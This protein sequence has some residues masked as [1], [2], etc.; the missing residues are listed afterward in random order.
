MVVAADTVQQVGQRRLG[1]VSSLTWQPDPAASRPHGVRAPFGSV[2]SFD[3]RDTP[4][5]ARTLRAHGGM[6]SGARAKPAVQSAGSQPTIPRYMAEYDAINTGGAKGGLDDPFGWS[7]GSAGDTQREGLSRVSVDW[8]AMR[9]GNPGAAP[10]PVAPADASGDAVHGS[11][12]TGLPGAMPRGVARA[13]DRASTAARSVGTAGGESAAARE[14]QFVRPAAPPATGGNPASQMPVGSKGAVKARGLAPGGSFA[15]TPP[16]IDRSDSVV[17]PRGGHLGS[18]VNPAEEQ[19]ARNSRPAGGGGGGGGS[20]RGKGGGAGGSGGASERFQLQGAQEQQAR[21]V[22]ENKA[23]RRFNESEK[24]GLWAK[25]FSRN[26]R[27]D[28]PADVESRLQVALDTSN[29]LTDEAHRLAQEQRSLD[30]RKASLAQNEAAKLRSYQSQNPTDGMARYIEDRMRSDERIVGT[31]RRAGEAQASAG[32]RNDRDLAKLKTRLSADE[33]AQ[34]ARDVSLSERAQLDTRKEQLDGLDAEQR[35]LEGYSDPSP[36]ER[37]RLD[38]LRSDEARRNAEQANIDKRQGKLDGRV[39]KIESDVAARQAKANEAKARPWAQFDAVERELERADD[40][41]AELEAKTSLTPAERQELDRLVKEA[42]ERKDKAARIEGQRVAV[43]QSVQRASARAE[44]RERNDAIHALRDL[45]G[46]SSGKG[47]KGQADAKFFKDLI[48]DLK[49]GL[50]SPDDIAKILAGPRSEWARIRD[51]L[52]KKPKK[53]EPPSKEALPKSSHSTAYPDG[54]ADPDFAVLVDHAFA[55]VG[56][57]AGTGAGEPD[58]ATPPQVPADPCNPSCYSTAPCPCPTGQKC[59]CKP[60]TGSSGGGGSGGG[61]GGGDTRTTSRT[62]IRD[63][64]EFAFRRVDPP[65]P[66]VAIHAPFGAAPGF[67]AVG[68]GTPCPKE[69]LEHLAQLRESVLDLANSLDERVSK[70]SDSACSPRIDR[71]RRS[72]ALQ[73]LSAA[74]PTLKVEALQ[75]DNSIAKLGTRDPSTWDGRDE[76]K[77][78]LPCAPWVDEAIAELE[79]VQQLLSALHLVVTMLDTECAL[80]GEY[81]SRVN[82]GW[83]KYSDGSLRE[84]ADIAGAAGVA[85]DHAFSLLV[86]PWNSSEYSIASTVEVSSAVLG[87]IGEWEQKQADVARFTANVLEVVGW[88]LLILDVIGWATLGLGLAARLSRRLLMNALDEALKSQVK[89]RILLRRVEGAIARKIPESQLSPQLIARSLER[90]YSRPGAI[91]L[92][93]PHTGTGHHFVFTSKIKELTERYGAEAL[94]GKFL[95]WFHNS[96]FNLKRPPSMSTGEFYELHA[97]L[98]GAGGASAF[99]KG[100]A[101]TFRLLPG[102]PWQAARVPGIRPYGTLGYLWFGSTTRLKIAAGAIGMAVGTGAA[103]GVKTVAETISGEVKR[104]RWR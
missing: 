92:A 41:Q 82:D 35:K 58:T 61:G 89:R 73:M 59:V 79:Y 40:R 43:G 4:T 52:R 36:D 96:G 30:D 97:K 27:G 26:Y 34:A 42:P 60:K 57:A 68:A 72:V 33:Y 48:K 39:A 75:R 80:W 20:G 22:S 16:T 47:A 91:R 46:K 10:T 77:E 13:A 98:H 3:K 49:K 84:I 67:L 31:D 54:S 101:R 100:W 85:V 69:T 65:H 87:R 50:L 70:A 9:G 66:I 21:S 29:S 38:K 2:G 6:D 24:L 103:L 12:A 17:G 56:D 25:V 23:K 51:G 90:G 11:V 99:G 37:K 1:T 71:E 86:D 94:R 32:R 8:L 5:D 28:D 95:K 88:G 55:S 45:A 81:D 44:T 15:T 93:R 76:S 64:D 104:F 53:T 74:T 102:E 14:A 7:G 18:S 63:S 62:A 83:V 19:I 78:S